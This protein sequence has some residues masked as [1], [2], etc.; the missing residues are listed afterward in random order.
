MSSIDERI[1]SME[2]DNQQ[3]EK[4]ISNTM[5]SLED[6]DETIEETSRNSKDSFLDVEDGL[7]RLDLVF[8]GFYASIGGKLADLA[9]KAAD[10]AN[11]MTFEQIGEG[12]N[13]YTAETLAAQTIVSNAGDKIAKTEE[14]Q[15]TKTYEALAKLAKYT[16]ETSYSYSDLAD[17]M[18]K[19]VMNGTDLDTA[20]L[21]MQGIGN[22]AAV[23]G[24]GIQKAS[25]VMPSLVKSV[26]AGY[27]RL[28]DWQSVQANSMASPEFT[29]K[30][31][32]A[33]RRNNAEM[34]K[35]EKKNGKITVE[36]F[37]ENAFGSNKFITAEALL[38]VL[39]EYGDEMTEVGKKGKAAAAEAK[40]MQEAIGAVQDAVSS[41]W[42]EFFR[43]IFGNYKEA[44]KVFT[45]IQDAML[46]VFTIGQA[47]RNEV[48]RLW[49]EAGGFAALWEGIENTWEAL[50][51]LVEPIGDAFHEIFDFEEP[52]KYA[53]SLV[54]VTE[55]FRDWAKDVN[56]FFQK[57]KAVFDLASSFGDTS[58]VFE[59]SDETFEQYKELLGLN[60]DYT[61][62]RAAYEAK[63][64]IGIFNTAEINEARD[65]LSDIYNM[66][67]GF[68]S[69]ID[70]IKDTLS[71]I[72]KVLGAVF[73]SAKKVVKPV[74][75]LGGAIG[76]FITKIRDVLKASKLLDT[77]FQSISDVVKAILSPVFEFLGNII[78]KVADKINAFAEG[79]SEGLIK[80]LTNIGE[81][82][83]Q[84]T[85][86][87][88]KNGIEA[89]FQK[90]KEVGEKLKDVLAPLGEIFGKIKDKVSEFFSSLKGSDTSKFEDG[91]SKFAKAAGDLFDTFVNSSI[92]PIVE[93]IVDIFKKLWEI[94]INLRDP[95]I[96]LKDSFIEFWNNLTSKK[97]EDS[98]GLF[99]R[100]LTAVSN[101]FRFIVD[102]GVIPVIEWFASGF[103]T[104]ATSLEPVGSLFEKVKTA[105]SNFFAKF[106][107][108]DGSSIF[109]NIINNI[110]KFYNIVKE[111]LMPV[112]NWIHDKLK[113]LGFSG[114][115]N[116]IVDVLKG[117][118]II[119]ITK[120][121]KSLSGVADGITDVL[122]RFSSQKKGISVLEQLAIAL[123]LLCGALVIMST[124]DEGKMQNAFNT[125]GELLLLLTGATA[126]LSAGKGIKSSSGTI[127]ALAAAITL[128]SLS[129]GKLAK[130]DPEASKNA[131]NTIGELLIMLG[132][133]SR[134]GGNAASG[135]TILA[136]SL[137]VTILS[138]SI[139]R[140]AEI[141]ATAAQNGVSLIGELA[142]MLGLAARIAGNSGSAALS[143]LALTLAIKL[144][145]PVIIELSQ[146][147]FLK[148]LGA[149]G[150]LAAGLI[151][152]G[153]AAKIAGPGI[154]AIGKA[155]LFISGSVAL[156]GVG[157][158]AISTGITMLAG[159]ISAA[160]PTIVKNGDT[161][162]QAFSVLF[163]A[164]IM[165]IV[166]KIP[167]LAEA[168]LAGL[169]A[170]LTAIKEY[171]PQI[172]EVALDIVLEFIQALNERIGPIVESLVDLVITIILSLATAISDNSDRIGE[173]IMKMLEA[174]FNVILATL[175]FL[176]TALTDFIAQ[177][178]DFFKPIVDGIVAAANWIVN[179]IQDV[180]NWFRNAGEAVWSFIKGVWETITGTF[181][182]II[183][184]VIKFFDTAKENTSTS[185]KN[186]RNKITTTIDT[187]V[188]AVRTFVT[189]IW[190]K[191]STFFTDAW[192][193]LV[194]WVAGIIKKVDEIIQSVGDFLAGLWNSIYGWISNVVSSVA[195]FFVNIWKEITSFFT[196][197]PGKVVEFFTG[198]WNT[199]TGWATNIID[200]IKGIFK[201]GKKETEDAGKDM[202][203]ALNTGL[204]SKLE[205]VKGAATTIWSAIKGVFSSSKEDGKTAGE[206]YA[207]GLKEGMEGKE[208]DVETEAERIRNAINGKFN[209][210]ED[211]GKG[212]GGVFVDKFAA[213][214]E[215]AAGKN[216]VLHSVGGKLVYGVVD[217][218]TAGE[219][220]L[221]DAGSLLIHNTTYEMKRNLAKRLPD[222]T[223][224]GKDYVSGFVKGLADAEQQKAVEAAAEHL[225]WLSDEVMRKAGEIHSP[226]RLTEEIG[227]FMVEGLAVGLKDD[228]SIDG[229]DDIIINLVEQ[230]K[231]EAE[232]DR[233]TLEN[234]GENI[235]GS[236]VAGLYT[237]FEGVDVT[238]SMVDN[239]EK[240]VD[241]TASY[242]E[243]KVDFAASSIVDNI[244]NFFKAATMLT[245]S[246][247][248]L[249]KVKIG[250]AIKTILNKF[251]DDGPKAAE[252]LVNSFMVI[253]DRLPELVNS[254]IDALIGALWTIDDRLDEL[255]AHLVVFVF[256]LLL[257]LGEQ[258]QE[259]K[260]LIADAVVEIVKAVI[261]VIIEVFKGLWNALTDFML[262][263]AEIFKP[264]GDAVVAFGQFIVDAV[265][266]IIEVVKAVIDWIV[267]AWNDI[268]EFFSNLWTSIS[269]FVT[270]I[271]NTVADIRDRVVQFFTDVFN[272]VVDWI[273]TA[274][275]NITTF[276]TDI[277]TAITDFI[278]NIIKRVDD[279]RQRVHD[280]FARVFK[281][282]V[283][284]VHNAWDSITQFFHD[285]WTAVSTFVS[286]TL[287]D[288]GTFFSDLWT[289]ITTFVGDT[290][291]HIADFFINIWTEITG[292]FTDLPKKLVEFFEGLWK[293][294]TGWVGSIV[295]K[296]TSI[297][298][299]GKKES[300]DAGKDMAK[301]LENG[302][303][304][305]SKDVEKAARKMAHGA[306]A[307]MKDEMGIKSPSKVTKEFG[308]Y[309][310]LGLVKGIE[311]YSKYVN[312]AASNVGDKAMDKL[313][314]SIRDIS[315]ADVN[316]INPVITP[317]LDLSE[318]IDGRRRIEEILGGRY[319]IDPSSFYK[320]RGAQNQAQAQAP[321]TVN[322]NVYGT[323]GQN[324]DQLAEAVTRK[325][326]TQLKSAGR[327]WA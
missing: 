113:E 291:L 198:I 106:K 312:R 319:S 140:L 68:F 180:I 172:V 196:E 294:V 256:D 246:K 103:D 151:A 143:I 11:S 253:L 4:N 249:F 49:H 64:G 16:D 283:D 313:S 261:E 109:T 241:E 323:A 254:L 214:L 94:V 14:E 228:R 260:G 115:L 23:T 215:D 91:F 58:G 247:L 264:I 165:V 99:E 88:I 273:V 280:F 21:A 47:F 100:I 170:T 266:A 122:S 59:I 162:K 304:G 233:N 298:K 61:K 218:L 54:A 202:A 19:F 243:S 263:H 6:L 108:E 62:A 268:G 24:A 276:F 101:L 226:S 107:S 163:D 154:L 220:A 126:A 40:T 46:E 232:N 305:A 193:G 85:D 173:S 181:T 179:A 239:I 255:V 178:A 27:L 225:I 209:E 186:I 244:G 134:I 125:I 195:D 7:S 86:F 310:D 95:L 219:T 303:N 26:N 147:D 201:G 128:I 175:K 117:V 182:R 237:G 277:W 286:D 116:L 149:V 285:I 248:G 152:I 118:L 55:K 213:G 229:C 97:A 297:F 318:I 133:A 69:V 111:K 9:L 168:L 257:V 77:I 36:N 306:L 259:N 66:S 190:T 164:L 13:K 127:I 300:E 136:L 184:A 2:F 110:K 194:T 210:L 139:K 119:N 269:D 238:G 197:L 53:D 50:K 138:L 322:V 311:Q 67:T 43:Y 158:I 129:F 222:I 137:A 208:S 44:R 199:V 217:G 160:G 231:Q 84:V 272:A 235:S 189:N 320:D 141:D 251:M 236:I 155:M 135:G 299:R 326:N 145:V 200:K 96:R 35:W 105:I 89:A 262:Q 39:A 302:L 45:F 5:R 76:K 28:R 223:G 289:N 296:I 70:I 65:I 308:R 317:V 227:R 57:P 93:A 267:T 1:V 20:E 187:V 52:Q 18:S 192:N 124:L 250:G 324:V 292:F 132:V 78:K 274:W 29:Q 114:V 159:A 56:D 32:D 142:V 73:S 30:L 37:S 265:D 207:D 166:E 188:T 34:R 17:T 157:L 191:I 203:E 301:G 148:A 176:W 183:T 92:I 71:G 42:G 278:G 205:I 315:I 80:T 15:I 309:I 121:V 206:G 3:F 270:N 31:I 252:N 234:V 90:L 10:F 22:W 8:A 316:E 221:L 102:N 98:P 295:D 112:I 169:L 314:N 48:A 284:W 156:F 144:L 216:E 293:T 123:I 63:E 51:S 41:S 275:D 38:E 171:L 82:I 74:L 258:L 87:I 153:L 25:A 150:I 240:G 104:L 174:I 75:D 245:L 230:F 12:F 212:H 242:F 81:G 130:I 131:I 161:I 33:A 211:D 167:A 281:A 224:V 290:L 146:V 120:F 307:S 321:M 327:V 325:I 271:I 288:I 83:K 79:P 177:N 287:T 279:T 185:L 282:I 72:G 60:D 204:S